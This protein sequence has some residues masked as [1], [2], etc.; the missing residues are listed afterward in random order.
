MF[1]PFKVGGV[2]MFFEDEDYGD[3]EEQWPDEDDE[4]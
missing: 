4:L 3:E 2:D 1:A